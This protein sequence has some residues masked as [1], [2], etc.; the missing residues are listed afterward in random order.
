LD[1]GDVESV[2]I[3]LQVEHM[4]PRQNLAKHPEESAY[5]TNNICRTYNFHKM[6]SISDTTKK[7]E[8]KLVINGKLLNTVE[9][10]LK[11]EIDTPSSNRSFTRITVN[12]N[13]LIIYT[14]ASDTTALRASLNS[15]LR[16]IQGIQRIIESIE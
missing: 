14:E 2:D 15:Y 6:I 3:L 5:K 9:T 1:Y 7:A 8:I 13:Q 12:E 16:W 11:P 10:A 4:F